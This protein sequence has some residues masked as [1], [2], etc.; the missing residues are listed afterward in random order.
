M[1]APSVS[2]SSVNLTCVV[3][4]LHVCVCIMHTCGLLVLFLFLWTKMIRGRQKC[5]IYCMSHIKRPVAITGL[6]TAWG[7]FSG[8]YETNKM[9]GRHLTQECETILRNYYEKELLNN[10]LLL[11]SFWTCQ[12]WEVYNFFPTP[13]NEPL[14][15]KH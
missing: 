14:I 10:K 1:F 9:S 3:V 12:N 5:S 6:S 7:F 8:F 15:S 13:A 11:I 4:C 2:E